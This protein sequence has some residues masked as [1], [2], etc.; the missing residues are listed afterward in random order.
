MKKGA[1]LRLAVHQ[2]LYNIYRLNKTLDS[3]SIRN[4]FDKNKK[5]DIAFIYNVC[6]FTMRYNFHLDKIIK[7]Y[8]K[9][10]SKVN[11]VILLKS[12]ITQIVFLEFKEYAVIDSS[13]EIAKKFNIYHG[14]INACLKKIAEDKLNLRKTIKKWIAER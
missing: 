2:I 10:K 4:I 13:V 14:F 7:K 8:V 1:R 6:L 3:I 12:A 11:D 5:S 9:K